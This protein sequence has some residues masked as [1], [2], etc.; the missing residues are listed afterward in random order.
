MKNYVQHGETLPLTAPSGGVVSGL[1]YLI[2]IIF[3]VALFTAAEGAK[4]E[5]RRR[6]VFRDLPKTT[7]EAW[8]EGAQLYWNA[9]TAKLT[10]TAG[11]NKKVA[12]ATEASATGDTVGV[13]L[14]QPF[15]V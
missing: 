1:P 2:G 7:G 3:G 5:L 9:G 14:I 11:N 15:A 10:T 6:G 8:T 12:I 4:F 13:A